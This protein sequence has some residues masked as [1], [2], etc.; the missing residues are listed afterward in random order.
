MSRVEVIPLELRRCDRKEEVISY[1]LGLPCREIDRKFV[2]IDWCRYC[3]CDL[4]AE[5]V[6]RVYKPG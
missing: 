3:G 6:K 2:Y 1:I 4:R 5:D